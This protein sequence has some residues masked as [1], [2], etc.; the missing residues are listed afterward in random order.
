[1]SERLRHEHEQFEKLPDKD[2][3]KLEKQAAEH[4]EKAAESAQEKSGEIDRILKKIERE[5]VSRAELTKQ[6]GEKTGDQDSDA[7]SHHQLSQETFN[8]TIRRVQKKLPAPERFLSKFIHNSKVE[9]VSDVIGGSIARP[10]GLLWGGLF[11]AIAS[12]S[13]LILC[14]YYGFEYNF[15][16][17]LI[18]FGGG[19]CLGLLVESLSRLL[20]RS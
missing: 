5:A 9:T 4:Y 6:R 10:S 20:R 13:V 3:E 15:S 8:Q 14:R 7:H 12:L 19:F 18:S 2:F 16:I 11:S 17:G 1:M